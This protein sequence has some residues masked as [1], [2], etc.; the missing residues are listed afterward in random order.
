MKCHINIVLVQLHVEPGNDL[1]V[2][3]FKKFLS[4]FHRVLQVS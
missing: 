1:D 3:F 2:P 4:S